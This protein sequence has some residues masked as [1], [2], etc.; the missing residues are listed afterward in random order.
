MKAN[1]EM[2]AQHD[3]G[4]AT[5]PQEQIE[6]ESAWCGMQINVNKTYLLVI[7]NDENRRD[8]ES[9]PLLTGHGIRPYERNQGSG[10]AKDHCSM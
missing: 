3:A 2:D 4:A 1:G 10:Q 7:D 8:Q 6:E 9:A 5:Q